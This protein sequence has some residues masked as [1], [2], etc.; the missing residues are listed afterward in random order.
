VGPAT[1]AMGMCLPLRYLTAA[2]HEV[3]EETTD[4]RAPRPLGRCGGG[5][6]RLP[7]ED[8]DKPWGPPVIVWSYK[9]AV[10]C[11]MGRHDGLP[12]GLQIWAAGRE[13]EAPLSLFA[14]WAHPRCID[15]VWATFVRS[16]PLSYSRIP[17]NLVHFSALHVSPGLVFFTINTTYIFVV[18]NIVYGR[19]TRVNFSYYKIKSKKTANL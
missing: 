2:R 8:A 9:H 13:S 5:Q 7:D 11:M 1:A 19:D 10:N 4:G 6:T 16:S 15:A 3:G 14:V 18:T 12:T 17:V